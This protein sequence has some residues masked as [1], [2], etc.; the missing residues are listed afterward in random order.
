MNQNKGCSCRAWTDEELENYNIRCWAQ[1]NAS[2]LMTLA[3]R[4]HKQSPDDQ[5]TQLMSDYK[6]KAV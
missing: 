3:E 5:T 1:R 2:Q 4:V 6:E